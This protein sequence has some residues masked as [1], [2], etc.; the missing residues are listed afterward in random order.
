[1]TDQQFDAALLTSQEYFN[2][3]VGP[4]PTLVTP[5]IRPSGVIT[6]TLRQPA[7]LSLRVLIVLPPGHAAITKLKVPATRLVGT[8]PLGHH[9]KGRVKIRWNL[10]VAGHRLK[11]GSY[12]L[13]LEAKRGRKL[14]DVSDATTVR[15]R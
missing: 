14:V 13:V 3:F 12:A 9:G 5:V 15:L 1:L 7:T 8:V 6:A 4:A 2:D 10:S 11:A